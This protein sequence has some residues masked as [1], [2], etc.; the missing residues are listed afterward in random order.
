MIDFDKKKRKIEVDVLEAKITLDRRV[1]D[2]LV[3]SHI[4]GVHRNIR[5][6]DDI[7][8]TYLDPNITDDVVL[9]TVTRHET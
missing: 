9:V 7:K 2:S 5:P 6:T 8:T 4:R 1:I 3:M